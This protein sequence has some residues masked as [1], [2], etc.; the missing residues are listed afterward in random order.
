MMLHHGD[1]FTERECIHEK[2]HNRH[3]VVFSKK[4][5]EKHQHRRKSKQKQ[6]RCQQ[7]RDNVD[8]VSL[9]HNVIQHF[10][11]HLFDHMRE[12]EDCRK[13]SAYE[14]T[15][16]ITACI[17]M[18]IFK[19]GS[20][21]EFNNQRRDGKF[22]KN[23]RRL[24][25][26]DLPHPDTVDPVMRKL[27]EAQL[28]LLKQRMICALLQSKTLHKFRFL[29]KWFVVAIDGSGIVSY[30]HKHCEQ[31]LHKTSKN[32]KTTYFH[33]VLEAKLITPNGFA[34]SMATEWIANPIGE[35]D[36][37]DCERNAFQRLAIQLK[38]AFPRLPMCITADALLSLSRFFRTL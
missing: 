9:L 23:Y 5:R 36:K 6:R 10:F 22:E 8:W 24:F 12:L 21:N 29:S 17:A 13:K 2:A 26:L 35:Y 14:L 19:S 11:P 7:Q 25:K 30:T 31:C 4:T 37:Q 20:R 32:G 16:I 1:F 34:I 27:P 38:K 33:A 15:E 18:F 3:T 28:T